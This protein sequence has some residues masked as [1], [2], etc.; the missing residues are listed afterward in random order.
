MGKTGNVHPGAQHPR[1]SVGAGTRAGDGLAAGVQVCEAPK[2]QEEAEVIPINRNPFWPGECARCP[3]DLC[4]RG[5]AWQGCHPDHWRSVPSPPSGK[6]CSKL[7]PDEATGE[8]RILASHLQNKGL[9][10]C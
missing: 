5:C 7:Q 8:Q 3:G 4:E 10:Y 2:Q 9:Q 6:C 1:Q